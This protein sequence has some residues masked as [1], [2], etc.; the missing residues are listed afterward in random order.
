MN[1]FFKNSQLRMHISDSQLFKYN[2]MQILLSPN[3]SKK[4]ER[5]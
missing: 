3:Q 4:L 1:R 5:D 2:C